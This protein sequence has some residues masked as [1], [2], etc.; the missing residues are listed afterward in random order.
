ME[1][2][3]WIGMVDLRWKI[4][5]EVPCRTLWKV[6]GKG[7]TNEDESTHGRCLILG[8]D[9]DW[10]LRSAGWQNGRW[11]MNERLADGKGLVHK[12]CMFHFMAHIALLIDY[13]GPRKLVNVRSTLTCVLDCQ[14][15]GLNSNSDWGRLEK[16]QEERIVVAPSNCCYT[17]R[18]NY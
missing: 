10:A 3:W 5:K 8:S 13:F 11:W 4:T 18:S 6:I 2:H 1:D 7:W 15:A 14:V 9:R 12:F 16:R 17:F